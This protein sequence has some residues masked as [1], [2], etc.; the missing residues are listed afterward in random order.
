MWNKLVVTFTGKFLNKCPFVCLF[1]VNLNKTEYILQLQ[2]NSEIKIWSLVLL[3]DK[4]T[5][6]LMTMLK[7]V[8]A[9]KVRAAN[10]LYKPLTTQM[11]LSQHNI[12]KLYNHLQ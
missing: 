1:N 4:I 7:D 3:R 9:L 8:D 11:L 12:L 2:Y 5:V 10:A 6:Y